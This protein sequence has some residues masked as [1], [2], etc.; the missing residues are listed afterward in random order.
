MKYEEL[1]REGIAQSFSGGW[2]MR[3][4]KRKVLLTPNSNTNDIEKNTLNFKCGEISRLS[5][6]VV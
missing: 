1:Y 4:G 6:N 2:E 5:P 3:I